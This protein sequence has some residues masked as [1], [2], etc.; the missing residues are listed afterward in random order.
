MQ[1]DLQLHLMQ[2]KSTREGEDLRSNED[3]TLANSKD[4][5]TP[6]EMEEHEEEEEKRDEVEI[7]SEDDDDK[8]R[9]GNEITSSPRYSPVNSS[10]LKE[11]ASTPIKPTTKAEKLKMAW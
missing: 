2:W 3:A 11:K 4:K 10:E 6:E 8:L 7:S 9:D 1:L 5:V